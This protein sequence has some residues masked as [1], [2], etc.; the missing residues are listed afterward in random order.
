MGTRGKEEAKNSRGDCRKEPEETEKDRGK[1]KQH[2]QETWS[3]GI[4]SYSPVTVRCNKPEKKIEWEK[5]E[6]EKTLEW[7]TF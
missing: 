1:R 5:T 2:C 4:K 6:G 7:A 3:F